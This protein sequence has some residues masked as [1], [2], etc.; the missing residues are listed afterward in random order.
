MADYAEL[1]KRVRSQ[2][3]AEVFKTERLEIPRFEV[4][5]VGSKTFI[6]NFLD[7]CSIIRREPEQLLRYLAKELATPSALE[8]KHAMFQGRFSPQTIEDKFRRYLDTYVLC[9]ECGK[10]DT[11]LIKEE[12]LSFVKCEACGAR[13][14]VPRLK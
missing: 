14:V 3:P 2:L 5:N 8:G 7:I 4:A 11:R 13:R 6:K 1:L 10:P 9:G 12:R